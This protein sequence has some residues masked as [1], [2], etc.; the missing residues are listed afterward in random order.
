M[1]QVQAFATDADYCVPVSCG[2]KVYVSQRKY[3]D[4]WNTLT[5]DCQEKAYLHSHNLGIF[6]SGP[7]R[8]P[9]LGLNLNVKMSWRLTVSLWK[10][11]NRQ[12]GCAFR[13]NLLKDISLLFDPSP[14]RENTVTSKFH[15]K[16]NKALIF[17]VVAVAKV[18]LQPRLSHILS[19]H[20]TTDLFPSPNNFN[21]IIKIINQKDKHE[22]KYQQL[23][24]R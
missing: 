19:K 8:C 16:R 10:K 23:A 17:C 11:K 14:P 20:S 18:G 24:L 9:L 15:Y 12:K 13:L 4:V 3:T 7:F 6:L 22:K 1:F 2:C 5:E 21:T